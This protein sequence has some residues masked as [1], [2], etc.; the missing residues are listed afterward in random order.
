MVRTQIQITEEQA[1]AVKR[2]ARSRGISMAEVI[3]QGIDHVLRTEGPLDDEERRR[4]A[5]S[6]V[7]SGRSGLGDL[8]DHHDDYLAEAYGK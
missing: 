2:L 4:R 1:A 5:L 8:A 3:R 7:G 6:I